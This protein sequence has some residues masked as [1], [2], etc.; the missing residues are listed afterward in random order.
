MHAAPKSGAL[1]FE[2]EG[3]SHPPDSSDNSLEG[4]G[5][6]APMAKS[7]KPKPI[8]VRNP[9][10]VAAIRR[11]LMHVL[12]VVV[13][14]GL[15]A[16]GY[17]RMRKYVESQVTAQ[18]RPPKVVLKDRPAWMSDALAAQI[19]RSLQPAGIHSTFD[20]KLLVETAA[21]LSRNP[22]IKQ[23]R[24]IRRAYG[25]RPGDTLEIDC[26]FRA[27]I[28]LVHW[29][30]FYWL[31]DSDA[32]KL[33]DQFTAQQLSSIVR[34]RDGRLNLRIIEGVREAPVES[35][36]TWYGKDLAAALDMVKLLFGAGW[37]EEI[38]KVD[39]SNF[40]GAI[41]PK[42]AH[43]TLITKY[44][45]S[46]LWGRPVGDDDFIG[47]VPASEKL[48]RLEQIR[49]QYGRIDAG[50]PWIDIRLDEVTYPDANASVR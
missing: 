17:W 32:V 48:R 22:W 49:V 34:G 30:D 19:I 43:I 27:P 7:K 28:A 10:Q 46:I 41:E 1:R 25:Q 12:G 21:I 11:A 4:C 45:T 42:E 23:V 9:E 47:E 18:D 40:G 38:V 50:R 44:G 35:G 13:L 36:R 39:V 29:K 24:E 8:R 2:D 33:P 6:R 15:L 16:G 26:D 31:V 14:A 5:L 3:L 37:A 20:R